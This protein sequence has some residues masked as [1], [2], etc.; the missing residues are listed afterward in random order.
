MGNRRKPKNKTQTAKLQKPNNV[1]WQSAQMNEAYYIMYR[2]WIL[3]L[4]M[5]RFKWVN[6]PET[7]DARYL[8]MILCT[9]G[10]ATIAKAPDLDIWVS[11]QTANGAPNLYDDPIAWTSIGNNGWN[12]KCTPA[13]GVVIYDNTL[14]FPIWNNIEIWSRRLADFDRTID[15]NLAHQKVPWVFGVPQEKVLDLT[16]IIK[17]A[18]GGEPAILGYKGIENIKA[19][20]LATP[21]DFKGEELQ[22]AKSQL[23]NEIYTYLGI[24][25]L[26]KKSERMIESEVTS[27][28]EPTDIR[29]LAYLNER[30]R[31]CDY[32]NKTFGLDIHV[33]WN[34]D[35]ASTNYNI[36]HNLEEYS[37]TI[38]DNNGSS[39]ASV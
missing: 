19:E 12:F 10:C 38:G 23:W 25:N 21:V 33:Y 20:L 35:N 2:S 1:F 39:S 6:L 24:E 8:E 26:D 34:Q 17:Q 9:Q 31:A 5:S 37:E 32:L 29:A 4:A 18:A 22:T 14:R 16:N 36:L 30:R 15:V 27:N 13:N 7:C 3:E 11:T 28:N